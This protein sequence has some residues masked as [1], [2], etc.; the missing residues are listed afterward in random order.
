[1]DDIIQ[2]LV[3]KFET[4]WNEETKR[5]IDMAKRAREILLRWGEF[6]EQYVERYVLSVDYILFQYM[7]GAGFLRVRLGL[8]FRELFED[9]R[10]F[11]LSCVYVVSV[12]IRCIGG[13]FRGHLHDG[14]DVC[15][16]RNVFNS[17][18]RPS[19]FVYGI[20]FNTCGLH[21][22]L[23]IVQILI[24][25]FFGHFYFAPPL[26]FRLFLLKLFVDMRS[27]YYNQQ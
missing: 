6:S 4:N 26:E 25:C 21:N 19:T 8:R 23:D 10:T 16:S 12:F 13:S 7:H 1:M 9:V 18:S 3:K 14:V 2:D 27:L 24:Q 11:N 17:E 5:Q 15:G 20:C 22:I